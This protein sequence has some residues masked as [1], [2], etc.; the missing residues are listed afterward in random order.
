MMRI[1]FRG[2][3]F[4]WLGDDEVEGRL[5]IK[6]KVAMGKTEGLK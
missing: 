2:S 6:V 5:I 3:K 1:F 4:L